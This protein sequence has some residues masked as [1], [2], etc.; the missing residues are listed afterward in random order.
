MPLEIKIGKR[1]G[2]L[3]PSTVAVR[4][5]GSLDTATAPELEKQ[6]APVYAGKA[7]DLVFDLGDLHFISSAGLR[8][9]GAARKVF[10][11]RGGQVSFVNLQAQVR[12]VF[13][14]IEALPGIGIFRDD[15]EMDRYLASQTGQY[16]PEQ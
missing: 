3:T 15:A 7:K 11:G 1:F 4:L 2:F 12:R 6:L 8:V 16:G 10:S 5:S 13:E 9:F 14:I